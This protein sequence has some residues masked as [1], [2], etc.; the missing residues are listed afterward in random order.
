MT[1]RD[2]LDLMEKKED[3][4]IEALEKIYL[5]AAHNHDEYFDRFKRKVTNSLTLDADGVIRITE[6][7]VP[8][9]IDY[10]VS[11]NISI[12]VARIT[13]FSL[14]QNEDEGEW[15]RNELGDGYADFERYLEKNCGHLSLNELEKYNSKAYQ[16]ILDDMTWRTENVDASEWAHERYHRVTLFLNEE[17]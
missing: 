1:N 17:M 12:Y 7:I 2:W 4:I 16:N 9:S 15:I 14:W 8:N 13:D 11:N 3:E 5:Q 6:I 10:C